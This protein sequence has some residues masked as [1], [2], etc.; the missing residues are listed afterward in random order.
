[1]SKI[2]Y[3]KKPITKKVGKQMKSG[4][5]KDAQ[6][7]VRARKIEKEVKKKIDDVVKTAR[8]TQIA[9]SQKEIDLINEQLEAAKTKIRL[10]DE[11]LATKDDKIANLESRLIEKDKYIETVVDRLSKQMAGIR[12]VKSAAGG[13]ESNRP[14]LQDGAFID[15]SEDRELE[16]HI[17]IEETKAARNVMDDLA[18]LKKIL[19]K[20]TD[21]S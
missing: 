11:L 10:M 20:E 9:S 8:K 3:N 12:F 21:D 1:M 17:T 2:A 7:K 5:P 16:P 19:N 18:K 14:V 4:G 13:Q 6:E 15:P